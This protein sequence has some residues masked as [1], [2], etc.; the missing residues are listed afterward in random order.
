MKTTTNATEK[1][2]A[3]KRLTELQNQLKEQQAIVDSFVEKPVSDRIQNYQDICNELGI[4]SGEQSI[5]VKA[6]GFDA[7]KTSVA[8]NL[9]KAMN[10]S[11]FYRGGRLPKEG[12]RR[13]YAWA[14]IDSSSPSGLRFDDTSYINDYVD[15]ASAAHLCFFNEK[16]AKDAFMKFPDVYAGFMWPKRNV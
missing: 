14:E 13:Y 3:Q 7:L 6:D 9:I 15:A 2:E 12:E 8:V 1:Q 10:I 11:E 5:I 16:D 4:G